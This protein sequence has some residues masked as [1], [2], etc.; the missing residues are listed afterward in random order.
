MEK[1]ITIEVRRG[2]AAALVADLVKLDRATIQIKDTGNTFN[3][4]ANLDVRIFEVVV[5]AAVGGVVGVAA[6]SITTQLAKLLAYGAEKGISLVRARRGNRS[7]DLEA[8][9]LEEVEKC[10]L[11]LEED[12]EKKS[13]S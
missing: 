12:S 1:P 11:S 8:K 4:D 3:A 13:N 9:S 2:H 10:I 7:V 5:S 6:S